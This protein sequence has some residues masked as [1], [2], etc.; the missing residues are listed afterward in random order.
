MPPVIPPEFSRRVRID[1]LPPAGRAVAAEA[2]E[3]ERRAL[4]GRLGLA[5]LARLQ[6]EG[7][8]SAIRGGTVVR[9]Q[10]RLT[11]DVA[12][13][14]VVTLV[15]LERHI[16]AGFVRLYAAQAS[17]EAV[18][19]EEVFFDELAEDIEPLA[20]THIDVGEAAAEQLALELDPYPRA[21]GAELPPAADV[22]GFD[23]DGGAEESRHPFARLAALAEEGKRKDRK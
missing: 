21:P 22:V 12:Q 9:L 14:C 15:P 17:G 19:D 2:S 4:A 3:S 5:G 1:D 20:G 7:E 11:A 13:T 23:G 6:L 18:A 16:E 8:V 10:A